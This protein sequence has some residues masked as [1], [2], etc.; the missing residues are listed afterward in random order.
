VSLKRSTISSLVVIVLVSGTVVAGTMTA[1]AATTECGAGCMALANLD[2]GT[3]DLT[4][5]AGGHASVQKPVILSPAAPVAA[6]DWQLTDKGAV[7]DLYA[8]GLVST[9][10]NT[11]FPDFEGYEFQFTPDGVASGLCLGLRAAARNNERVRLERCGVGPDTIWVL[12]QNVREGRY[13]PLVPG[14]DTDPTPLV[15]TGDKIG[16]TLTVQTISDTG[17]VV[18]ADQV[19]QAVYGVQS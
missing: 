12:D 5:V 2:F 6:E 11:L 8:E 13:E 7:P 1:M 9:E 19:W 3:T 16:R 14:S 18:S 17:G 10:I 4:A 15:L